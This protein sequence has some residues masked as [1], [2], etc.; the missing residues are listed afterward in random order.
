MLKKIIA[1]ALICM[2]PVAFAFAD[3]DV[4]CGAG[5]QIWEGQSG[6]AP[7]VLAAT[8]NGIFGNQT[9]GITSGTL[10]C[11]SHGTITASARMPMFASANMEQLAHDMAVGHG[12]TLAVMAQL[13]G[14]DNAADRQAFYQMTKTHFAAIF[15]SSDVTAGQVIHA[16]NGLMAGNDQLAHYVSK[17]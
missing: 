15:P 12:E 5:T 3:N 14:I 10:G 1:A 7:K 2:F 8:T 13:Y 16:V 6:L 11:S 4:G 17:A 9:F